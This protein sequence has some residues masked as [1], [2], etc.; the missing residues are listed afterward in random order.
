MELDTALRS[1]AERPLL[2]HGPGSTNQL[3]QYVADGRIR[4]ARG[5][6]AN[7]TV[8]VL[9]DVGAVGL[10]ALA[11]TVAAA[12]LAC[13]RAA[14]EILDPADRA[15]HGA[16]AL[17]LAGVLVAWQAT[18]GLWQM[19]GYMLFGLLLALHAVASREAAA[20]E[21]TRGPA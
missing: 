4:R 13:R 14:R 10:A 11:F 2:G 3:D 20:A 6:V 8:F 17:G 15:D 21:L 7:G 1:A 16:L 12:A 19:Y 9:H 18:H 5:W